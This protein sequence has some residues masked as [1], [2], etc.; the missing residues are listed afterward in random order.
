MTEALIQ[1]LVTAHRNGTALLAADWVGTVHDEADA[2]AVQMG[3]AA[4]LGWRLDRWKSGGASA[5]GPFSHSPVNPVAGTA[6]LG[7][8]AEVA[9]RVG[10]D[11][12]PQSMCVAIELVASRWAEGLDA[13]ALLRMADH[14]SNAGLLLGPWQ[15]YRALDWG[16]LEWRLAIPGQPDIVRRGGH[17]LADPAGVLPSWLRHVTRNGW[18]PP[19]GTVVTTG[20]W[21]GLHSW[22]GAVRGTLSVDGLGEFSFSTAA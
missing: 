17:S 1:A 6:L 12:S 20:A 5:Q 21:G 4:A 7:V 2:Y 8:E 22:T 14:Q 10:A 11:G 18:T 13:P 16:L 9:L 3:V 19:A 15:P